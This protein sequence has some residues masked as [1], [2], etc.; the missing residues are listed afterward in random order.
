MTNKE[1][2]NMLEEILELDEGALKEDTVLKD[3]E[4]WTSMAALSLI[5]LMDEEFGKKLTGK[6]IK[7]FMTVADILEQMN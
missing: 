6:Q 3:L 5:V 4:E 7:E 2:I 1:K